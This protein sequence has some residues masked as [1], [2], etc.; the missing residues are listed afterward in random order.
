MLHQKYGI[1]KSRTSNNLSELRKLMAR[2][3]GVVVNCAAQRTELIESQSLTKSAL[4]LAYILEKVNLNLPFIPEDPTLDIN[5]YMAL[6]HMTGYENNEDFD[7]KTFLKKSKTKEFYQYAVAV[8]LK[9]AG[10]GPSFQT[11]KTKN[12]ERASPIKT[13]PNKFKYNNIAYQILAHRF[14]QI[15]GKQAHTVLAKKLGSGLRMKWTLDPTGTPLGPRGLLLDHDSAEAIGAL[16][17]NVLKMPYAS[18]STRTAKKNWIAAT[19]KWKG[20]LPQSILLHYY[21]GWWI[22]IQKSTKRPIVAYARGW[23]AQHICIDLTNKLLP[24]V[25]L[26]EQ[27]WI[28]PS[29]HEAHFVE[30]YVQSVL[31][32]QKGLVQ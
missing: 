20:D 25:Q 2:H 3:T 12:K 19:R 7:W 22:V 24:A 16:A 29:D 8:F 9:A 14:Y 23:M 28:I 17:S 31:K 18:L 5:L 10:R 1:R 26:R 15:T 21:M 11:Q 27:F 4:G 32:A 6:N 30:R 13:K